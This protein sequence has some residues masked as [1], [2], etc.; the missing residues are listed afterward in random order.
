MDEHLGERLSA[1]V[2]GDLVG[3]ALAGAEAHLA[4]CEECRAAVRG[5]RRVVGLARALDDRP[6]ARD[7]WPDIAERIGAAAR[8]DVIPL[9]TR[10]RRFAF[11]VPQLAAA[12]LA[13]SLV[14]AGGALTAMRLLAPAAA[15]IAAADPNVAARNVAD[16]AASYDVA[17]QELEGLLSA[18]RGDLD[19]TTVLAIETS[20]R[21]INLAIAQARAAVARDPNDL[22]LN[23]HLR[24][25]LDRKLDVL[26]RA[27]MFPKAI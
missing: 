21:V 15:P 11:S 19:S 14:S 2:D 22:Y 9:A 3:G 16:P 12:G 1:Y 17:I 6:P 23:D 25:T 27:A 18:R 4:I 8:P 7:L 5:L 10:R 24:S 26:R 20:L 13:L